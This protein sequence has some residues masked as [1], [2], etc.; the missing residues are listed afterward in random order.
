[1]ILVIFNLHLSLMVNPTGSLR[2]DFLAATLGVGVFASSLYNPILG[3]LVFIC[4][5]TSLPFIPASTFEILFPNS[6]D[7]EGWYFTGGLYIGM[8]AGFYAFVLSFISLLS[9]GFAALNLLNSIRGRMRKDSR[10]SIPTKREMPFSRFQPEIMVPLLVNIFALFWSGFYANLLISD[11]AQLTA[12]SIWRIASNLL[13]YLSVLVHVYFL[14]QKT[15]PTIDIRRESVDVRGSAFSLLPLLFLFLAPIAVP[16]TAWALYSPFF[17][18]LLIVLCVI[19]T[20]TITIKTS[21]RWTLHSARSSVFL[22]C[23]MTWYAFQP[24][25]AEFVLGYL[26]IMMVIVVVIGLQ[27]ISGYE[28]YPFNLMAIVGLNLPQLSFPFQ[29][30][31]AVF[32]LA[33][34][35]GYI[36]FYEGSWLL[37]QKHMSNPNRTYV[38]MALALKPSSRIDRRRKPKI[39]ALEELIQEGV[40]ESIPST[41]VS[42]E[43]VYVIKSKKWERKLASMA[44]D[45]K[46]L[47]EIL[48]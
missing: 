44:E 6:E 12:D 45:Q 32:F 15:G 11:L 9:I 16:Q 38:L 41:S 25:F 20:I 5:V 33:V 2:Y 21:T 30:A 37:F 1:M 22:F 34:L 14:T 13:L 4:L 10:I 18:T 43:Q 48:E 19:W 28:T 24:E 17:V 23:A 7:E 40:V 26:L 29:P 31:W 8:S 35:T 3:F 39:R 47:E 36:V 42:G 27:I 46:W